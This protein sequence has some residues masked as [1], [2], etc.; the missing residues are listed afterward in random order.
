MMVTETFQ[1][2]YDSPQINLWNTSFE[3]ILCMS[4]EHGGIEGGEDD[5]D[6]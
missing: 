2:N 3:G 6:L 4:P 1:E 5:G